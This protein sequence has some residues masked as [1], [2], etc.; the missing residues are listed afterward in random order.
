[1]VETVPAPLVTPGRILVAV[2]YSCISIGTEM[3]GVKASGTPLWQRALQQPDKVSK[4]AQMVTSQGLAKTQSFVAGKLTAGEPTGYS[5][6]GY[7]IAV[8]SGVNRFQVGDVVA[9][10]GA[11]CAHHAE[12]ICIPENLAVKVP[13]ALELDQASTVTLG[14]IALQGIRRATPTLGEN[15]VVIGLGILGQLT[16]QL[17]QANGCRVIG[18]DLDQGRIAKALDLG[19]DVGI[20]PDVGLDSEEVQRLTNGIGADGVIVTAATP[21]DGVIASAFHVCR[22]KGRVILVGDVGLNINRADIYAK[23]LDFFI[24]TSYGPGRYDHRYEEQGYDYP[25]AYVRWTENRNMEEYLRLVAAGRVQLQPLIDQVYPLETAGEAYRTLKE[26]NPKPLM[27]LLAYPEV[28]TIRADHPRRVENP[29]SYGVTGEKIRIAVVGAGNFAKGTHLPNLQALSKDFHLRAIASRSGHNAQAMAKK[30]GADYGT[31]DYGDILADGQVDAIV[32]ATRHHLHGEMV[33]QALV[34][35]KHV[36]VEKPLAL[37]VEDLGAIQGF[38][39]AADKTPPVLLT[40]FNRRFSP[41]I[42]KIATITANRDHPLMIDYQMNAG[43]IPLDHWVHGPEGGGRNIGE[44]CHLYDLSTFLTGAAVTQVKA[45]GIRPKNGHYS[46]QDNFAVT[47]A[48]E[49]G[50]VATL[51]YTALGTR[52][53]PK[54]RMT[55]FVDGKVLEMDDYRSLKV[56][57]LKKRNF[58][59]QLQDKGQKREL[60]CFAQA[61]KNPGTWPIPLWQQLQATTISFQVEEQLNSNLGEFSGSILED[62]YPISG[63]RH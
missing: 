39:Q 32:I 52:H 7:V 61:L 12:V 14:A 27:V 55:I 15:F 59:L 47:L 48:F 26:V 13:D 57:G 5:A 30:F 2:A 54:E 18:T 37:N 4:V 38:Y 35:G 43:F 6:S 60:Q 40:G 9:C 10:A 17:L 22:K 50:S 28:K 34:A 49:D 33:I 3:I 51:T 56:H 19:L 31:T 16:V 41:V 53:F 24:S 46:H 63:D 20:A 45:Q 29:H 58:S 23:E 8:G 25:L 42:E 62:D 11:Q 21:S 1:M 36:L 44:A